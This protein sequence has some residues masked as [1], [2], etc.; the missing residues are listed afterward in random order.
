MRT[1]IGKKY[2]KFILKH[3]DKLPEDLQEDLK[4]LGIFEVSEEES[5]EAQKIC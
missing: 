4:I 2:R 3:W 5:S 1:E